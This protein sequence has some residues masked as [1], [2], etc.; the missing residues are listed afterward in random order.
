MACLA[1]SPIPQISVSLAPPELTSTEP[2]SPFAN[3]SF[4]FGQNE[5]SFRPTHLSP[6]LVHTRSAKL[7]SFRIKSPEEIPDKQTGKGLDRSRFEALLNHSKESPVIAKKS[8]DLRKEVA[9]KAHKNRQAERRALFLSKV[10]APP[11]PTATMTPA[12]PP[13]SPALFHYTL[14]SP[15]LISP[16]AHYESLYEDNAIDGSMSIPC[17]PWVEQVDF[18][19]LVTPVQKQIGL[20]TGKKGLPSLD[21]ISARLNS[22]RASRAFNDGSE[23][24]SQ[25]AVELGQRHRSSELVVGRLRMPV[26]SG[27]NKPEIKVTDTSYVAE[28]K[29][30]PPKSPLMTSPSA[31]KVTTLMVPHIHSTSPTELTQLN[32][33]ALDSRK[34][35]SS[36]MLSTLRRRT[37]SSEFYGLPEPDVTFD[38]RKSLRRRSAP[39]DS[40]VMRDRTGFE[41]PVLALP[42]AF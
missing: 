32:L 12:T 14:P 34:T 39:A 19:L 22:Y 38:I 3:T 17:K 21:Q 37:R 7:G 42:G 1:T 41:H 10:L 13:E 30:E 40:L 33:L 15:G 4:N 23:A 2:Y 26:R 11:S 20:A 5:D 8:A 31:L 25:S 35:R 28:A 18:K 27:P 29:H 36:N 9:V 6:P 24:N 16:I